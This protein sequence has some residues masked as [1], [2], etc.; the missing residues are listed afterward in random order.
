MSEYITTSLPFPALPHS[1]S[2]RSFETFVD[3][4]WYGRMYFP[5]GNS[6]LDDG[7]LFQTS[8]KELSDDSSLASNG[9]LGATNGC[10]EGEIFCWKQCMD[11]TQLPCD[12]SSA[13]CFDHGDDTVILFPESRDDMCPSGMANC[14]LICP[15]EL[16]GYDN[17]THPTN[18]N[19]T[20]FC[21]GSGTS[22]FMDGFQFVLAGHSPC[23][24]WFFIPATMDSWWKFFFGMCGQFILA[25]AVEGLGLVRRNVFKM[26]Q[27]ASPGQKS[28]YRGALFGLHMLQAFIGYLIMLGAMTYSVE[29][30]IS[31]LL[32][33]GIGYLV[34]NS[35]FPPS[36]KA[37]PCCVE[38]YNSVQ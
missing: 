10:G 30:M 13:L 19:S 25:V 15:E 29:V 9:I 23:L 28:V 20:G 34:F 36:K 4:G 33:L 32:G 11:A 37:E 16:N 35:E 18:D 26:S 27:D 12:P 38:N 2:V 14:E 1:L 21:T 8:F 3:R 24:N 5:P 7:S 22:M 6:V 31:V 17:T